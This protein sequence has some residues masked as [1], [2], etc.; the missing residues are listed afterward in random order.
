MKDNKSDLSVKNI[1]L[2]TYHFPHLKTEQIIQRFLK[3]MD[4]NLR[5]FALPYVE[6]KERITL[7]AHRPNQKEAVVP[8]VIAEKHKIPYKKCNNDTEIDSSCDFY[9]ILGAGIISSEAIIGKKI[10]NCHP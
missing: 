4:I 9:L 5:I 10:I 2:I 1:G 3:N 6:K 7:F 8:E